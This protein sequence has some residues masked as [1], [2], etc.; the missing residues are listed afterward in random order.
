MGVTTRL[1][2]VLAVLMP[3]AC[4]RW[5]MRPVPLAQAFASDSAKDVAVRLRDDST[6]WWRVRQARLVG[7][8]IVGQSRASGQLR[9]VT[10][11]ADDVLELVVR[12][13]D[14][15]ANSA[16]IQLAEMASFLGV[17]LFVGLAFPLFAPKGWS[18]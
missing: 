8:S 16:F 5:S 4:T 3:A 9:R 1:L 11:P 6:H 13:P 2:L 12:E 18:L 7:D 10:V 17:V 15:I 14:R